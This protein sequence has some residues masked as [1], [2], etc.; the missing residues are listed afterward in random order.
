MKI[1][2]MSLREKVLQTVVMRLNNGRESELKNAGAAFFFGEI[3]TEADETGLEQARET[4]KK[5]TDGCTVPMLAV[6][7][8]E[9]GCGDMLK[10]LTPLPYLMALGAANSEEIAYD[11]GKATAL[12]ARS[13]G[14][15][16][17]FS[18]VCDL[19]M[20]RRNPLV[21]IRSIS[22]DPDLAIRLL[23]QVIRGMQDNG[24]AACAKHFPGD[25]IDWR[26]QHS[27]TTNNTLSWE[28]WKKY[29]GRVFRELI[30]AGV[31]SIMPGHIT[32]PAYQKE[33][34]ANGM[35]LP[36]T[37][38][39]ELI[40]DLLKGEMG[41]EGVV[42]TDALDMGGFNGWYK[43]L[44][45]AEIEAFKAGNDML[46]WP[47]DNYVDNLIAAVERGEVSTERLDDAVSRILNMKEKLGLFGK[48]SGPRPMTAVEQAF[49]R[50]TQE[51]TADHSIT[52]VR[53]KGNF[54]PLSP[55]KGTR[56][57]VCAITHHEPS[58]AHGQ[59]LVDELCKRG[60]DAKLYSFPS[61]TDIDNSDVVI[62]AL[63]SRSFRPRGFLDFHSAEV[64]KIHWSMMYGV[65]K[66]IFVSFGSPYFGEQYLER[67]LTYVNAYSMTACSVEAFAR[68]AVGEIPF[69]DF[70]PVH[71]TTYEEEIALRRDITLP[72]R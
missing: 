16:W 7:D 33:R 30:G 65:E 5:Y 49:V 43:D 6:S 11:Y 47:S 35:C 17:T 25:G 68:A 48:D 18:P 60:F 15:N 31:Y 71:L 39:H 40:T 23:K 64:G 14:A 38:S 32:L 51:K 10:G 56:I 21:N 44:E 27:M 2:D 24:L 4:L 19:N 54:F 58:R 3:I 9:N 46:L 50:Q 41:F 62:Y 69:T 34:H 59:V 29:S 37:L 67:A 61:F 57:A 70:S 36:A 12:E 1:A 52:L 66:A 28:D 42:V 26:D 45:T 72:F 53:D 20:N 55:E 13:I 22:D 8:F 63:F